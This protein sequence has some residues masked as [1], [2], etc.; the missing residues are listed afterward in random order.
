MKKNI[1][2]LLFFILCSN[3][4]AQE[5]Y[6]I[7]GVISE[8]SSGETLIGVNVIFPEQQR[9]TVT[10]GYGFYSI[11]LPTG[12]YDIEISYL[13]YQS[14]RKKIVLTKSIKENFSLEFA[15][16]L[17]DEVVVKSN[18]RI[19]NLQKPQMSV[20]KIGVNTIKEMPVVL[21][22]VDIIKSIQLLPGVTSAGEG[23]SGFNVRGG[24]EDQNL[25]LLDEA[26]LFSSSHL[27]GFFSIFNA[28]AVKDIK[29]YKGGIPAKYGGRVSSVLDVRQKDGNKKEHHLTGGI[30]LI[31][32]RL[33]AE[34]PIKEDKSSYLIAG[35]GSYAHL[36]LKLNPETKDNTIYFYDLNTKLNFDLDEKNKLYFSGYFGRDHFNID[37]LFTNSYGNQ[38]FNVRWNHLFSDKLFSNLTLIYTE[39]KY[40]LNL[41][42]I[43][44][45]WDSGI[46]NFNL[47]YDF[48]NYI[49]DDFSLSYGLSGIHYHFNPGEITPSKS[50][51]PIIADKLDQKYALE[52]AVYIEAEQSL[53]NQFS[54]NY[55]V[56]ISSFLRLGGQPIYTYEN[57][58][59][60]SFNQTLGIYEEGV[61]NGSNEYANNEVIKPF[62]GFEPRFSVSYK[63]N[64]NNAFKASYNRMFQ[65]I[66]LIS[67]TVSAAPLDVWTPSGTYVEPQILDQYAVGYFK[68]LKDGD[69]SIETEVYYKDVQ[70]RL[71]YRDGADL[72]A[73]NQIETIVLSGKSRS[74]GLEL[75]LK[76]NTG[77]FKGW[78]S[79]TLSNTEQKVEGTTPGATGINNG[80][81]Y[82]SPYHKL[83]DISVTTS[84]FLNKKWRFGANFVYQ[85][86]RPVTYPNG[87]YTTSLNGDYG[88]PSSTLSVPV[89]SQRNE[90]QL[91]SYHHLDIAA[92]YTP[93]QKKPRKWKGEWVFSIY[94]LY[95]RRNAASIDFRTNEDTGQNEAVRTS[96]FGFTPS[97]T[98]NFKF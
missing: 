25:V 33:M 89:F 54:M 55:G 1:L 92:T 17:I 31:S 32:S 88:V 76:K 56:R 39:Y 42:F 27:F 30:G 59:P 74:Y 4:Y 86:G 37:N 7:S 44:F 57:D 98:Y 87:Q 81:W 49:S 69:Y 23:A 77:N 8:K 61:V 85:S 45:D 28:D 40:F 5:T 41:D 93:K 38:T 78:I 94:N 73:Q 60:I 20:H 96:I 14:I 72:I 64:E 84:Y 65:Y 36:F 16:E 79:Y 29:L 52:T 58:E 91:P 43:G 48:K 67:N 90:F 26:T 11:T 82:K 24:G 47:K 83:H 97:F 80:N 21:G 12:A 63:P 35:R 62:Y 22:E 70:N 68:N 75:S 34:G 50:D 18:S 3:S 46:Q 51:S 71:D 53:S 95:G 10:N 66:H 19:Q 2:I 13:G 9:G 6:T 15:S